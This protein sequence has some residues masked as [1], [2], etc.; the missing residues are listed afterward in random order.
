M[1]EVKSGAYLDHRQIA[2]MTIQ[3]SH[4]G[5]AT[6]YRTGD[7]KR[8][9]IEQYEMEPI[10]TEYTLSLAKYTIKSAIKNY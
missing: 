6:N 4:G 1:C 8:P 10:A 5:S 3:T 9:R 7:T 2:F